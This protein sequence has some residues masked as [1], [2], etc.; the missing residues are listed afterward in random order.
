VSIV[1]V[2]PAILVY[3]CVF[4]VFYNLYVLLYDLFDFVLSSGIICMFYLFYVHLLPDGVINDDCTAASI[5]LQLYLK[6][7]FRISFFRSLSGCSLVALYFWYA[8]FKHQMMKTLGSTYWWQWRRKQFA[9]GGHNVP[10]PTFLL[11]PPTWGGTTIVCYWLRDN[12]SVP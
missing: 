8:Y 3:S 9:S 4:S 7:A 6:P 5:F 11:C 1:I 2:H 12:W 10:P